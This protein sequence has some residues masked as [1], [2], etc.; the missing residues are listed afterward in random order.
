M[1]KNTVLNRI[2]ELFLDAF[3]MQ[4]ISINELTEARLEI[5][6]IVLNHAME[7]ADESDIRDLEK[8]VSKAREKIEAGA[9]FVVVGNALEDDMSVLEDFCGA[10]EESR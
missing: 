8:N 9:D 6:R 10:V 2:S 3:R 5:E 4:T 1:I 7:N